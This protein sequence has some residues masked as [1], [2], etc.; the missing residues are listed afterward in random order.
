MHKYTLI[1]IFIRNYSACSERQLSSAYYQLFN[2]E[3]YFEAKIEMVRTYFE[4]GR[5]IVGKFSIILIDVF[6]FNG[7]FTVLLCCRSTGECQGG[8]QKDQKIFHSES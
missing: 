4:I 6:K 5:M 2:I 7:L 1:R 3:R 8:T